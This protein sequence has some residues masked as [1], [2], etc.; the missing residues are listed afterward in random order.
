MGIL[1]RI[2]GIAAVGLTAI[3]SSVLGC[4]PVDRGTAT[5][6]APINAA[7]SAGATC[8]DQEWPPVPPLE[9][10]AELTAAAERQARD[11]AAMAVTSRS[12]GGIHRGADGSLVGQRIRDAGYELAG[13]PHAVMGENVFRFPADDPEGE[14]RATRQLLTSPAHCR[15]LMAHDFEHV[16]QAVV[17]DDVGAVVQVFARGVVE[18]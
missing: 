2:A 4:A 11:V 1:G 9:A 6:L 10:D 16:G 3:V 15:T 8:G 7:R 14:A 13:Y 12:Q 5:W 18:R 17:V